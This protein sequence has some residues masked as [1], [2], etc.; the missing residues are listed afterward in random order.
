M[1]LDGEWTI[2]GT[3]FLSASANLKPIS[4]FFVLLL[5]SEEHT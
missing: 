2:V 3:F 5:L 4:I 1:C